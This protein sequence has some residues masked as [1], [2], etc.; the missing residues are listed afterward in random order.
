[1]RHKEKFVMSTVSY[2]IR[3]RCLVIFE[4]IQAVSSFTPYFFIFVCLVF[5]SIVLIFS[6]C[7]SV[8]RVDLNLLR[9]L[10]FDHKIPLKSTHPFHS[11]WLHCF[12]HLIRWICQMKI[13]VI[14]KHRVHSLKSKCCATHSMSLKLWCQI[15]FNHIA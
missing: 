13:Q 3:K 4:F 15:S 10:V 14:A 6:G 11:R 12:W 1:M 7:R 9:L 8:C 5:L 2:Y